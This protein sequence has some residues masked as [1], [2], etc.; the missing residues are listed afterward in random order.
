MK[1][2]IKYLFLFIAITLYTS[3][4]T[5]EEICYSCNQSVD[6]WAH[7]NKAEILKMNRED[8]IKLPGE[9]QRAA[10]RVFTP[11]KRK[12]VWR[13]KLDYLKGNHT[14]KEEAELITYVESLVDKLPFNKELTDQEYYSIEANLLPLVEKAGWSKSKMVYAFGTLQNFKSNNGKDFFNNKV[15]PPL[16]D[17]DCNC[18]WG[19]CGSEDDCEKDTCDETNLGC[20]ALGL[21]SCTKICGGA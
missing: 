12:S 7:D 4:E 14:S 10:F 6:K 1:N 16:D 21:G 9:K 20:G 17:P 15:A 3:C 5:E 19:W 8:I 11:Q 13:D 2:F 18:K